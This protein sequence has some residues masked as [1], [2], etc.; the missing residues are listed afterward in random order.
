[1]T[2]NRQDLF[3]GDRV[4]RL[5]ALGTCVTSGTCSFSKMAKPKHQFFKFDGFTSDSKTPV[6]IAFFARLGD[7]QDTW[8]SSDL[9]TD[10]TCLRSPRYLDTLADWAWDV[11]ADSRICGR[12]T[13]SSCP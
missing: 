5:S 11:I 6:I 12:A 13:N 1:M 10:T 2:L 3:L 7:N 8:F 4:A 9:L